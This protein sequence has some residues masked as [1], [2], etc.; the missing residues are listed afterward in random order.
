MTGL[1]IHEWLEKRGGA[2]VVLDAMLDAF[3]DSRIFALWDD[4]DGRFADRTNVTES[5]LARTALRRHK[6]AALP[7]MPL[8]WRDVR[9]A[10][11]VEWMLVSSNAFAHQAR[12]R[13][14]HDLPKYVYTHSP[15]RYI[16]DPSLDQ[17]SASSLLNS[18]RPLFRALDHRAVDRSASFAAN[19][20]FVQQRMAR[21][22]G[23]ESRVVY[24]P[25]PVE[26]IQASGD[27]AREL[28]DRDRTEVE[29]LPADFL[30]GVSRFVPY[31][32][33]DSIL[34]FAASADLP[35]VL[36]G[37]GPDEQ[38]LRGMAAELGVDAHFMVAPS[39]PMIRAL[40]QRALA[41]LFLAVE[42]FGIVPVEA[43]AAGGRVVVNR[44]GGA[45]ESVGNDPDVGAQV[46]PEDH[47]QIRA[48]IDALSSRTSSDAAKSRALK[49]GHA[50]FV[51]EMH[52]WLGAGDN[53]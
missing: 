1:I 20:A 6:A 50:R 36:A 19:S 43:L 21:T 3:P 32:R 42:D 29:A 34:E 4:S 45:A 31:K 47:R 48:A 51:T 44:L 12:V 2:E 33:L 13:A 39:T 27:W 9:G 23:V 7:L 8:V 37:A 46:D 18:V 16:W 35:V 25:V 5:W 11:D 53:A 26:A 41:L 10:E 14:R 17:R 28:D 30:L 40:Y 22:W 38:R 24:P 15:A 52:T 49:F